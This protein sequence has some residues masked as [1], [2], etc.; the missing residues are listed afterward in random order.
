MGL[1]GLGGRVRAREGRA[2]RG[3]RVG[4]G[5]GGS[6]SA[7]GVPP[8]R[9]R[10]LAGGWQGSR[11]HGSSLGELGEAEG[12]VHGCGTGGG[13]GKRGGR[14]EGARAWR[15]GGVAVGTERL[16]PAMVAHFPYSSCILTL[17]R[18][19]I[20]SLAVSPLT[21]SSLSPCLLALSSCLLLSRLALVRAG[22]RP[23][24]VLA[25]SPPR[26]APPRER[27][28]SSSH[29][30]WSTRSAKV[31]RLECTQKTR[32]NNSFGYALYSMR[33]DSS[34]LPPP[35][36]ARRAPGRPILFLAPAAALT[37]ALPRVPRRRSPPHPR[38]A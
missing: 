9:E 3:A 30:R 5:G 8:G 32:E 12:A 20:Y 14:E 19:V 24:P 10:R 1:T 26:L 4:P 27:R 28:A 22:L 2:L 38:R 23:T 29:D 34:V 7:G 21:S 31:H 18:P 33:P 36:L 11:A 6:S 35:A 16:T 25:C 13:E 37:P 17:S 15:G